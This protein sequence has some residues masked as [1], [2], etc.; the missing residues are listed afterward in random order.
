MVRWQENDA[1]VIERDSIALIAV[2]DHFNSWKNLTGVQTNWADGTVLKDYSG[3]NTNTI[4][5]YGGGK[6][7][8]SIPPCDGSAQMEEKAILFGG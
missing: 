3:A 1:L 5:V 4:T 6:V 8:I 2:N 7:D